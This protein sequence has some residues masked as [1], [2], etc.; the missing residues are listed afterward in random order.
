MRPRIFIF[1][2]LFAIFC[3]Q[4][5]AQQI[6]DIVFMS[7]LQEPMWVESLVLT[8][9]HNKEATAALFNH[10]SQQDFAALFLLGDMVSTGSNSQWKRVDVHFDK[11][12]KKNIPLYATLGNHEYMFRKNKGLKNFTER[13]GTQAVI[14]FSK[15]IDSVAVV[16]LNSNFNKLSEK[17]LQQQMIWYTHTM[18]SLNLL[19]EVKIII[20]GTHHSPCTNS[21][22]VEPSREVQQRFVPKFLRTEKAQLFLS[23]HSHNLEYFKKN[24]KHF[25][26]IGGGGGLKQPLLAR[27]KQL[28]DDILYDT[29]KLRFFY[30]I[31]RREKNNLIINSCG[32]SSDDFSELPKTIGITTIYL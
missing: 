30:L 6:N 19:R 3:G 24:E 21:T 20:V 7:D 9:E 13:F 12:R 11:I 25:L 27:E 31:V 18:D 8:T 10:L 23:G 15:I 2:S 5:K 22:I 14:G 17:E 26:V 32:F 16:L 28:Y 29:S 4:L 1:I